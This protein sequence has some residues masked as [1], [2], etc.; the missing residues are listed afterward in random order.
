M[1]WMADWFSSAPLVV[2]TMLAHSLTLF[3]LRLRI[4]AVLSRYYDP[5]AFRLQFAA[6]MAITL[7]LVMA[8]HAAEAALWATVYVAVG[9]LPEFGLATLYSLEAMTAYGHAQI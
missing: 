5:A 4:V 7:L 6:V 9:A 3:A 2:V 1:S 8:L